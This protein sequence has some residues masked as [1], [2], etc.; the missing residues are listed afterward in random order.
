MGQAGLVVTKQAIL[1]AV[2]DQAFDGDPNIVEV[3]VSKLRSAV[4]APFGRS[5]IETV[6]GVGYRLAA[7]GG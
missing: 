6:R 7:N 3:Y 2:W 5:S 1:D 4:D